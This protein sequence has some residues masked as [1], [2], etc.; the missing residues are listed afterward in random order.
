MIDGRW[1]E[2]TSTDPGDASG[3]SDGRSAGTVGGGDATG[4]FVVASTIAIDEV[5]CARL[6]EAFRDRLRAVEATPGFRGL[7]VWR[8]ANQPGRYLMVSWWLSR[9][10][11]LDYMRSAEHDASHA[12]IPGAPARPRPDGLRTFEVV[13]T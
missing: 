13:A 12:R 8:E 6:E 1:H 2:M 3:G 5:G 10:D 11:W 7:Q 9:A 4:L